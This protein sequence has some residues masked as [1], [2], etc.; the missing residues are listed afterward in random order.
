MQQWAYTLEILDPRNNN[1]GTWK[2]GV[3]K[4]KISL[5][6]DK[7]H[8][9]KAYRLR[10]VEEVLSEPQCVICGWSRPDTDGCYVY[11]GQPESDWHGPAIEV[12]APPNKLFVVFLF[13]DG[14]I[15]DWNWRDKSAEDPAIPAGLDG[16]VIW[17]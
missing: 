12:P 10:L 5:L 1:G 9:V 15:D 4:S 3:A 7:G 11:V 6:S 14:T 17:P 13:S 8:L 16:K 2:V